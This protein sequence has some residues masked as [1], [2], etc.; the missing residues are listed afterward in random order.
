MCLTR[1]RQSPL[2]STPHPEDPS[3]FEDTG[4]LPSVQTRQ[5]RRP[6]FTSE[7]SSCVISTGRPVKVKPVLPCHPSGSPS[8]AITPFHDLTWVNF[9][10]PVS[11]EAFLGPISTLLRSGYLGCLSG[12]NTE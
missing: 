3:T 6:S 11:V 5:I 10:G 2:G 1:Q 7:V 12:S 8:R 9:P 4:P